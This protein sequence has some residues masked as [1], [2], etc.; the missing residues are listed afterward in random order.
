MPVNFLV[1]DVIED[2]RVRCDFD[3]FDADSTLTATSVLNMV[4]ESTLRL[5]GV[6]RTV[7]NADYFET[8]GDVS[9][10]ASVA[11]VALPTNCTR[12]LRIFWV[13]GSDDFVELQRAEQQETNA[14]TDGWSGRVP[15][16]RLRSNG[17]NFFPTPDAVYTVRLVYDTGIIVA[18]TT[19]TIAG[20]PGWRE[21]LTYD[22]CRKFRQFEEKDSQEFL[23]GQKDVEQLIKSLAPR[24]HAGI[25]TVRDMDDVPLRVRPWDLL[26]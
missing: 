18:A 16:Y 13:R 26:R 12:L 8:S 10:T 15:V 24:D 17:I 25:R 2:A 7:Y 6:V 19:D 20:E 1:S 22:L 23:Q 5:S 9:T 14:W 21:W 11:Y 3:E 4:I